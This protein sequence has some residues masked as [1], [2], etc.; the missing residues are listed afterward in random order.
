EAGFSFFNKPGKIVALRDSKRFY[1]ATTAE[2][3]E[4]VTVLLTIS[5]SGQTGSYLVIFKGKKAISDEI[6]ADG[7]AN[8]MV[9]VSKNGWINSQIFLLF[10]LHFIKF[11]PPTRIVLVLMD[12]HSSHIAP[13][14]IQFAYDNQIFLLTFPSNTTHLLQTLDQSVFGPTKT[15]WKQKVKKILKKSGY[16]PTRKDFVP[17]FSKVYPESATM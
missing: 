11:A 3:R 9:T 14:A 1:Q 13:E 6:K 12:S 10:L 7:P 16:K 17:V 8:A 4:A 2:K 15:F 5:A